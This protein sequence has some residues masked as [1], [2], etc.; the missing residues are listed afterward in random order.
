MPISFDGQANARGVIMK[1]SLALRYALKLSLALMVA[2]PLVMATDAFAQRKKRTSS[3]SKVFKK[4]YRNVP[5]QKALDKY[6][7][8]NTPQSAADK[9]R[10]TVFRDPTRVLG[11]PSNKITKPNQPN[12][13]VVAPVTLAPAVSHLDSDGDGS[14]SRAEYFQGR[15]RLTNFG[16]KTGRNNQRRTKRLQS[17]FRRADSNRDGK[18]SPLE[19]QAVGNGRF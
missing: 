1:L 13:P 5:W 3:T 12:A 11:L 19:L 9:A 16:V 8:S 4:S 14:V 10:R 18:V 15:S 2:A 6:Y 17:Q 7:R